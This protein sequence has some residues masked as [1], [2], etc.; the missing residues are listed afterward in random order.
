MK[1]WVV[2]FRGETEYASDKYKDAE[3]RALFLLAHYDGEV[4]I[5]KEERV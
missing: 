4:Q 1:I 2:Y 5:K 3:D